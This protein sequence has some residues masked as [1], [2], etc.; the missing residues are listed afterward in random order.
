MSIRYFIP[1]LFISI[2]SIS[3]CKDNR[4]QA[5]FDPETYFK[6]L[7]IQYPDAYKDTS[8]VDDF[9]GMKVIDPYRWLEYT[10]PSTDHW[11]DQQR[12]LEASYLKKIPFRDTIA[13]RLAELWNYERFSSPE[14][15]GDY[16]Y[17]FKNDG[18]QNQDALYRMKDIFDAPELV[19]NPNTF[20]TDGTVAMGTHSFSRDGSLLAFQLTEGGS[21]WQTIR[22][23]DMRTKK[24]L[25]DTIRW[26]KF[27]G[28]SWFN[29]G[30]YYSRYPAVERGDALTAVNEFHQ[31]FYHKV[32]TPQEEDE[33]IFAD[34]FNAKRNVYAGTTKDERFLYLSV[35]ESTNGNALYFQR[36]NSG[37][38]YFEPVVEA[39]DHDFDV[40]GNV[41]EKLLVKTNHSAANSRLILVSTAHPEPGYWEE[42]IPQS[43]D[44][45]LDVKQAGDKIIVSYL[46]NASSQLKVFDAKGTL[47]NTVDLKGIGTVTDITM[48]TDNDE[49][50]YSFS[51]LVQPESIY[52][53]NLKDY[54]NELYKAPKTSFN[55]ED[56]VITQEWYQSYDREKI[57]IFIVFKKG[58]KPNGDAPAL[59]YGYGG[60][61]IPILPMYNVTRLNLFSVVLE[62]NGVC[63]VASLRGGS[64]FGERWHK[65]G[66]LKRKQTVFDDF[67][68]AAEYLIAQ[69][70]TSS[71]KLAIYGR[72]NGGLLVGACLTQ[73]PDLYKVA[74]PA[75][76]VMD[77][78]RYEKFSIGWAWAA[79]YG[80]ASDEDLFDYLYS[81]SPLHNVDTVAYP[82]TYITTADHDDRVAPAHSFK[83]AAAMQDK[84]KGDAP[85]LIRIDSSSGHGAGKPTAKKINEAADILSFMYYHLRVKPY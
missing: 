38:G 59:L 66:M 20:S 3:S 33:L 55:S 48:G 11:I 45:M 46:H 53:L 43:E 76:G 12:K 31:L 70:Y 25:T 78:L 71:E 17:I 24:M 42:V 9:F 22:V 23:M 49:V 77:M 37:E 40:V 4:N 6:K 30:F 73:R 51:T 54:K 36:L 80:S 61:N 39:F 85:I 79:E 44:M 8:I 1:F 15:H 67:Q 47:L 81:Y 13:R 72:S 27:S 5:T 41:G 29:D 50:F 35:V 58:F 64:E 74:I 57:P 28:I 21:D 7:D 10:S 69:K 63:A 34:R 56:Y 62:N 19:L 16:Y 75:V 2:F 84:Q 26:V 68:T 18:L 60:F 65:A 82:A 32:G 14:Q 52:H 83:F